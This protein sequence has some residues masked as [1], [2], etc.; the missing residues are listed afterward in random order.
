MQNIQ[1]GF[2]FF[3]LCFFASWLSSSASQAEKRLPFPL[4]SYQLDNGLQVIL[5]EDLSLPLVTVAVGYRAGPIDDKEG[6]SGLAYLLEGL[7]FSGSANVGR[8]QQYSFIQRIGGRLNAVTERDHTLF[9]Q[10]VPSNHLTTVLWMESD[11]MLSLALTTPNIERAKISMIEELNNLKLTNPYWEAEDLF[12]RMAYPDFFYNSPVRGHSDDLREITPEDVRNFY[13]MYYRPNNAVLCIV[14]NIDLHKT[15]ELV[16][17]YFL[18]IPKG[19]AVP[20][21]PMPS[22]Q[23]IVEKSNSLESSLASSPGFMLGY[24]APP[25]RSSDFYPLRLVE[26]VLFRGNSSRL[27]NKL[28]KKER[29]ASQLE[30]GIEVRGEQ[31]VFRIFVLNNNEFMK[32]ES[33]KNILSEINKLR[34]TRIS[35]AELQKAKNRLKIDFVKQYATVADRAIYLA[36]SFLED[37]PLA[38]LH[39]ELEKYMGVT[40]ARMTWTT[41]K[42]LN[43]NQ[44]FVDI[45]I[46]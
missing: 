31:A 40:A 35:E 1:K 7:M 2:V 23:T 20:N 14:G 5:S 36:R 34:T 41:N 26:Y 30:G 46:K 24:I 45:K 27:Y 15:R 13:S 3:C 38:E 16:N 9:Y 18:T 37:I 11:R 22:E 19:P 39:L 6:K 8:M 4:T 10:T 28:I 44:V 17:R 43:E 32:E 25:P 33:R 29:V 12:N 21:R 42:Y